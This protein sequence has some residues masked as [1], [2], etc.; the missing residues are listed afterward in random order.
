MEFEVTIEQFQEFIGAR[1]ENEYKGFV[2]I[3]LREQT[4]V[5]KQAC[6]NYGYLLDFEIATGRIIE[7]VAVQVVCEM[8]EDAFEDWV[9]NDTTEYDNLQSITQATGTYSET[10]TF[11]EA[12]VNS[13]AYIAPK[14]LKMLGISSTKYGRIDI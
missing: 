3:L 6:Q 12:G 13:R 5:L 14:F 10:R 11:S 7:D 4:N 8:T 1:V 9:N 2:N